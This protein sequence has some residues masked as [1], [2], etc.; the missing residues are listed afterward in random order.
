MSTDDQ[1]R[2]LLNEAMQPVDPP[3]GLADDLIARA[4]GT[5]TDGASGGSAGTGG[6][7]LLGLPVIIGG[8]VL[9]GALLGGAFGF[10]G[11]G[12]SASATATL[13]AVPVSACPGGTEV[14]M[15]YRGDRVLAIGRSGEWLAVRNVRGQLESVFVRTEHV[16]PDEI[17][18][19]LPE[20]GCDES[21]SLTVSTTAITPDAT[22]T[23][24][25][26]ETTTT[27]LA[28]TTTVP[29]NTTTTTVPPTTS[30]V[31]PT[32]TTVQ[33]TTT[34]APDTTPP[35]IG[36]PGASQNEIWE[37]N[38]LGIS[39]APNTPRQSTVSA[40]IT[41]AVGVTEVK[42]SWTDP[43]GNHNVTMSKSGNTYSIAVGPYV[44]GAW[45]NPSLA[46]YDHTMT[47]KITAKDA[48]GNQSTV[49][50]NVKVWEIGVC[51]V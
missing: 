17:L 11:N 34:T 25:P 44:A 19:G 37:Q 41:D 48:A 32:T 38:G 40:F 49:N 47:V 30:T 20:V 46:P 26:T 24:A 10:F 35:L 16:D 3:A 5:G 21:G 15:L 22:T 18:T 9:A 45:E 4:G 31:Q 8:A 14:G 13:D 51:F 50:V 29:E 12:G 23:T 43:D 39:C 36:Q 27:L 33:P 42:A 6:S 7:G 2:D 28:D 1:I